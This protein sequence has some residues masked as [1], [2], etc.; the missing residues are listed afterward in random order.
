M[1]HIGHCIV[2]GISWVNLVVFWF[3]GVVVGVANWV[4]VGRI[5]VSLFLGVVGLV[6]CGSLCFTG[7]SFVGCSGVMFWLLWFTMLLGVSGTGF[8]VRA[9]LSG[10]CF[11]GVWG[12]VVCSRSIG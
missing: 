10:F 3:A 1:G 4:V 12:S 6:G 5:C 8:G 9:A 11:S 2:L 7:V